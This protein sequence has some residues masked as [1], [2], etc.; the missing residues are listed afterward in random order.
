MAKEKVPRQKMVKYFFDKGIVLPPCYSSLEEIKGKI[1]RYQKD[2][3][4]LY[5]ILSNIVQEVEKKKLKTNKENVELMRECLG[6]CLEKAESQEVIDKASK[7]FRDILTRSYTEGE[8]YEKWPEFVAAQ[9]RLDY[10]EDVVYEKDEYENFT[11]RVN[12]AAVADML[13]N[14]GHLTVI[15]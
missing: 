11:G 15:R 5:V 12:R 6:K 9:R 13:C 4:E 2:N 8:L 14:F 7:V 1:E 10:L 3:P